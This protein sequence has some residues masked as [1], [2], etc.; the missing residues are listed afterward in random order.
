MKVAKVV[1]FGEW[2]CHKSI[3]YCTYD[4]RLVLG[5]GWLKSMAL[6]GIWRGE[7]AC[8]VVW[9][10]DARKGQSGAITG[11]VVVIGIGGGMDGVL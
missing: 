4:R 5:G 11:I 1:F 9:R 7:E 6:V 2:N 10:L 3:R 8:E